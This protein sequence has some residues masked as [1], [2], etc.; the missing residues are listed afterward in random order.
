MRN[1]GEPT[2]KNTPTQ[3]AEITTEMKYPTSK[4]I[5]TNQTHSSQTKNKM[6]KDRNQQH[7]R[8]LNRIGLYNERI[9]RKVIKM[10]N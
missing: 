10:E 3:N 7:F 4:H 9:P 1:R 8:R 5:T 2:T 6:Q